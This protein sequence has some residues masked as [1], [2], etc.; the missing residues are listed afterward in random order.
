MFQ[1][2]RKEKEK[3][4][5]VDVLSYRQMERPPRKCFRCD[6]KITLSQ[7]VKRKHVLMKKVIMHVTMAKII[8]TAR[9][10]HLW[11]KYLAMKNGKIMERLNTETENLCTWLLDQGVSSVHLLSKT[12]TARD[13]SFSFL[14][15][16]KHFLQSALY[17]HKM[18][19]VSEHHVICYYFY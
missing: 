18:C 15:L 11:H 10:M 1:K 9:Y 14:I 5:A 4:R 13:F 16:L 19:T 6:L 2:G 7:N 17:L 3:A 12:S 8:V